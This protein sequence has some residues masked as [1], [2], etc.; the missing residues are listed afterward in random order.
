METLLFAF[1]ILIWPVLSA[2]VLVL[3]V[4]TF[5]REIRQARREGRNIV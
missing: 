4:V 2:G 3:I 1:Y 5:T